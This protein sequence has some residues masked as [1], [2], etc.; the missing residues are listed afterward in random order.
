MALK[1]FLGSPWLRQLAKSVNGCVG[2]KETTTGTSIFPRLIWGF[3]FV[4]GVA[5]TVFFIYKTADEYLSE[6]TATQV[7]FYLLR[8][9]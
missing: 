9:V 7:R 6:P 5:S 2:L 1:T 3:L 4:A 8:F